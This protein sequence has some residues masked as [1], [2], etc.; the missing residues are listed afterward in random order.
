MSWDRPGGGVPIGSKT[1]PL[2]SAGQALRL[3][4]GPSVFEAGSQRSARSRA[5]DRLTT[6]ELFLFDAPRRD[7]LELDTDAS[8]EP[9]SWVAQA[10]IDRIIYHLM[11]VMFI[12][13]NLTI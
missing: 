7:R 1:Q 11:L 12:V 4:R 3:S 6:A 10:Q 2:K 9:V 5:D 13:N 8:G